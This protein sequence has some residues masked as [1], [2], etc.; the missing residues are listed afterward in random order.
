MTE[1][2]TF[3]KMNP[4]EIKEEVHV[5]RGPRIIAPEE[6][7]ALS[8]S[9][10]SEPI[11]SSSVISEPITSSSVTSEPIASSSVIYE[12]ITSS[13]VTSEPIASSSVISEPITSSSVT[14]EPIASSSSSASVN[15]LI[16]SADVFIDAVE[17]K[18]SSEVSKCRH[19]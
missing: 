17:D 5:Y 7:A 12:P 4:A 16:V 6:V 14:S 10:T 11:A 3:Q 9:V 2:L 1:T 19:K 13:S 18:D 8:R 15:R